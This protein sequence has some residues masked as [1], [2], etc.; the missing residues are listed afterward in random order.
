MAMSRWAATGIVAAA[1]AAGFGLHDSIA[2]STTALAMQKP[3]FEFRTYYAA[4]G[5][6]DALKARFRDH[7]IRIFRKHGMEVVAFWTPTTEVEGEDT[8]HYILAFQSQEA[9]DAAWRAFGTDPEW[10]K[11]AEESQRDG[12]LVKKIDSTMLVPTYY[13]PMR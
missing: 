12:R 5:K 9:R 2:P 4:P 11:V 10:Q 7:T 8:L 13:S 3:V 1:F 6:L